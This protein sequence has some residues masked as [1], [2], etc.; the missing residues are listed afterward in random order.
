MAMVIEDHPLDQGDALIVELMA[1]RQWIA[2]QVIGKI[3]VTAM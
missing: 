2:K 3:S 1:T